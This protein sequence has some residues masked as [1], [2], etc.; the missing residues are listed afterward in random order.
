MKKLLISL[1]VLASFGFSANW[2]NMN[3][4]GKATR[5]IPLA[6]GTP[7]TTTLTGTTSI[8]LDI[9][10]TSGKGTLP[11]I[12]SLSNPAVAI[13]TIDVI[14]ITNMSIGDIIY[15]QTALASADVTVSE[16][17]LILLGA[18]S[19][20]LSDPADIL[21]LQKFSTTQLREVMYVDNN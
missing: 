4:D 6:L 18:T 17:A 10:A 21:G 5:T 15:L 2:T 13:S 7:V 16:S 1:L 8:T 11:Q 3:V 12:L 19:R 20:F 14:T 9:S